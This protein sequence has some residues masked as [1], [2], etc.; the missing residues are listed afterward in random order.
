MNRRGGFNRCVSS[1]FHQWDTVL[2]LLDMGQTSGPRQRA[3]GLALSA[4]PSRPL[5]VWTTCHAPVHHACMFVLGHRFLC[6]CQPEV[7]IETD[8]VMHQARFSS[9]VF[10]ARIVTIRQRYHH[11]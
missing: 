1:R 7:S 4:A 2:M 5:G 10:P 3:Q 9:R 6:S 8:F 11:R